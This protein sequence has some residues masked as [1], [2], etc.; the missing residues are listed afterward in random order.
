MSRNRPKNS[1]NSISFASQFL[2]VFQMRECAD[3]FAQR[4]QHQQTYS[5]ININCHARAFS[6]EADSSSRPPA[7]PEMPD[8]EHRHVRNHVEQ[9]E[10]PNR[11]STCCARINLSHMQIKMPTWVCFRVKNI[12]SDCTLY[13]CFFRSDCSVPSKAFLAFSE[14]NCK[15]VYSFRTA[16]SEYFPRHKPIDGQKISSAHP[17]RPLKARQRRSLRASGVCPH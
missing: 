16:L 13:T 11:W 8:S 5:I 15:P 10:S 9:N 7:A 17:V 12:S 3:L 2:C 14:T 6:G 4:L 1:A